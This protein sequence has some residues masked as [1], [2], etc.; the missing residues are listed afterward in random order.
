[1]KRLFIL[2]LVAIML[3]GCGRRSIFK[4]DIEWQDVHIPQQTKEKSKGYLEKIIV[5][6]INRH[7]IIYGTGLIVV[8]VAA[9]NKFGGN[10]FITTAS[11]FS[12]AT[13]TLALVGKLTPDV[14]FFWIYNKNMD[15]AE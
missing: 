15:A 13:G 9:L 8:G 6:G 5:D 12:I 4:H 3:A 1:M 10:N 2:S 7:N 14:L 11:V